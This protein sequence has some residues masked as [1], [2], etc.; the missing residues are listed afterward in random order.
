MV[1]LGDSEFMVVM[2]GDRHGEAR[3]VLSVS[4]I[5]HYNQFCHVDHVH[6]L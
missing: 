4:L 6:F 1:I 2:V 5:S 3:R